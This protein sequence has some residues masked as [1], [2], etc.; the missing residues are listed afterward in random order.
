MKP[1]LSAADL[2]LL[3]FTLPLDGEFQ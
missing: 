1:T 3:Y 2:F